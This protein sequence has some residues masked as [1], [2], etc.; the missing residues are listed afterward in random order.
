[1]IYFRFFCGLPGNRIARRRSSS[2]ESEPVRMSAPY[3]LHTLGPSKRSR[4][5]VPDPVSEFEQSD[6]ARSDTR[7]VLLLFPER[8]ERVDL[9]IYACALNATFRFGRERSDGSRATAASLFCFYSVICALLCVSWM[10]FRSPRGRCFCEC[11]F[12]HC[13]CN[14]DIFLLG[15]HRIRSDQINSVHGSA[16]LCAPCVCVFKKKFFPL[17]YQ[18]V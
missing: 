16:E 11:I 8:E 18:A 3:L 5:A 2:S 4:D 7:L 14:F 1:M 15:S 9:R 12:T 6:E 17:P 13:Q 10:T